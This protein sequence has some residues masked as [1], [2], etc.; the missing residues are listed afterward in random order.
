MRYSSRLSSH[1]VL[2]LRNPPLFSIDKLRW[3]LALRQRTLSAHNQRRILDEYL[4]HIFE[5]SLRRLGI[6]AIHNGKVTP[7]NNRKH[8]LLSAWNQCMASKRV[9]EGEGRTQIKPPMQIIDPN[10]RELRN[11][12]PAHPVCGCGSCGAACAPGEGVD[13]GVVDPRHFC[14]TGA[15]E[16]VVEEEHGRCDPAELEG[17]C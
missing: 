9:R 12:K 2:L 15:V 14:E 6:Q 13:F 11:D 3:P 4:I 1:G 10:F 16:E 7:Y 8:F 17:G 5:R